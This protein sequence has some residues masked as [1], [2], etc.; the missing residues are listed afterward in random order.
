[1]KLF[2]Q[3]ARRAHVGFNA[4]L[5]DY[6]AIVRICQLVAGMPLG[7]ELAAAWVRTLACDEIALEIERGLGFLSVS[8][9]DLPA[10]HRS[11]R[12]VF[13]HSWK[14]LSEEERGGLLRLS[15]FRGGFRREAAEVVAKAALT[16][17]S[18][19]VTKSLLRRSGAGRYDLHEVIRQFAVEQFTERPEEQAATQARHGSY[20]LTFFG[21]A[22][23]RLRSSAQHEALAELTAE[24]D[25]F[26]AAW[27]WAVAHGEFALIEQTL[28]TFAMLYDTRGWYQEGLDT[29]GHAVDALETAHGQS[30]PDR[31]NQVALGHLLTTRALLTYRLGKHEQARAMLERSLVILRPLN[32][33]RVIVE[34]IAFLGTV[35]T[36]T[37]DYARAAEL[38]GEGREKAVAV[39]DQWFAAMCLSLQGSV[40]M[41]FGQYDV[42]HEQLQAAMA[43][44]RAIGDPRFT[45]F[46]LNHLGQS[47]LILGRYDEARTA[48]EESVALNISVG[49]RWN[50]GHAYQGLGAVAQ[51]QGE[52][53]RAVDMFRKGVDT[54]TELGGRFYVGQGLAEMGRSVF[55]LGND[56]EAER[57]WRESL[58]IATETRG[59][60]VALTTVVGLASLRA[61]RGDKEHALELLS[62]ALNHPASSQETRNRATQLRAELEA[63]LTSQQVEA[64]QAWVQAKTFEVVVDE[65]LKQDDLT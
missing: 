19:L 62:M 28:R 64:T 40:A 1:M 46:G 55:A 53:Q 23:G 59:T 32:D 7:I 63:Q 60:P 22:D 14:L 9:R 4:T 21:Q 45:A 5:E 35:M 37:G 2:L 27:D 44:W 38:F 15:V 57:V 11:M 58:H 36:L 42:A 3:R 49:A 39:G 48:L 47:A 54:F 26:R 16:A 52:H 41:H 31:T 33:P 50:L 8:T 56:A 34:P 51:A 18:T 20:Y 61:K 29:L 24:M 65:L 6:P 12:A 17:L 13:D 30:P 25:N 10:R 43:E